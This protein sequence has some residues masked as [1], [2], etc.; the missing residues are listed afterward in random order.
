MQVKNESLA[1]PPPLTGHGRW[2]PLPEPGCTRAFFLLKG[3]FS[4]PLLPGACSINR[5]GV[6]GVRRGKKH[7]VKESQI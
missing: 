4:L 7:G 1:L 2:P 3:G 5:L 6:R